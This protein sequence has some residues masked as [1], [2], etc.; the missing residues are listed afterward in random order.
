MKKII[1][2]VGCL[3]LLA[4]GM[5]SV[6]CSKE[7]DKGCRCIA[8]VLGQVVDD[9]DFSAEDLKEMNVSNCSQLEDLMNEYAPIAYPE[10]EG[11]I[12]INCS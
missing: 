11:L 4:V 10:Y 2:L 3:S 7:K 8:K 1:L 12:T 6:A 5:L 9:E